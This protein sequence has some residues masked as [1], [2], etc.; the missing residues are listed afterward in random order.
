MLKRVIKGLLFIWMFLIIVSFVLNKAQAAEKIFPPGMLTPVG[1]PLY[2]GYTVAMVPHIIHTF[3]MKDVATA[4][5]HPQGDKNKEVIGIISH[6]YNLEDDTGLFL[7]TLSET[8]T[9]L[10]SYGVN[11]KFD[12]NYMIDIVNEVIADSET[13]TQ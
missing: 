2:C 7:L 9:C 8:Q 12:E 11:W 6:W 1:V 4:E 3:E 10:L 5:V 13:S